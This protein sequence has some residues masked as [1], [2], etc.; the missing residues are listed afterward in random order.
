[1]GGDSFKVVV[2]FCFECLIYGTP[3]NDKFELMDFIIG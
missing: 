3:E 2:L 1:M